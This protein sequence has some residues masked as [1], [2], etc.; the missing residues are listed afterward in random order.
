MGGSSGDPGDC[1]TLQMQ[2]SCVQFAAQLGCAQDVL[3]PDAPPSDMTLVLGH[4]HEFH[5]LSVEPD[6]RSALE[7]APQ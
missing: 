4:L 2:N 6:H 3:P 7:R 5:Y 1:G